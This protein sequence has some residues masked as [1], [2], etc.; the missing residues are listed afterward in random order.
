M[1][2]SWGGVTVEGWGGTVANAASEFMEQA[3]GG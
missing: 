1:S 2:D 3:V